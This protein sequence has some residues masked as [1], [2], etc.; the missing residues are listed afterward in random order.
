MNALRT[1]FLTARWVLAWFA[2]ALGVAA[3]SPLVHPQSL[4]VV[5]SAAGVFQLVA[6]D[7]GTAPD[8]GGLHTLDCALCLPG[9]APPPVLRVRAAPPQPLAHAVQP[10][11]AARI[12]ALVGAPLPARGPPFVS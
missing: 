7:D 10:V 5:C 2:L 11:A 3:V 9:G 6:Q 1:P 12:A 8:G 4:M